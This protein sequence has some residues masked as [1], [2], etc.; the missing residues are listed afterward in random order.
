MST[1]LSLK[2]R[3]AAAARALLHLADIR[4]LSNHPREVELSE[5]LDARFRAPGPGPHSC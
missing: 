3:I 4:R 1:E 2:D 5:R